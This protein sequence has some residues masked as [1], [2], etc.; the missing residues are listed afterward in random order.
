VQGFGYRPGALLAYPMEFTG[1]H[2]CYVAFDA[3]QSAEQVQRLREDLAM[4]A[5]MQVMELA[6]CMRHASQFCDA[7]REPCP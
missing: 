6:P 7:R 2:V 5:H 4:V 1:G 3:T